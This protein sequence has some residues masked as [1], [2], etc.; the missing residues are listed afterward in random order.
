MTKGKILVTGGAG[1]IGSHTCLVLL[2]SGYDLIVIDSFVNSSPIALKKVKQ[3]ASY[4]NKN[5]I[6]NIQVVEGDIRDGSV[7]EN[8]FSQANKSNS[9]IDGVI[10]FVGLKAVEESIIKPLLYWDVNV[11]GTSQLLSVMDSYKC[12]TIVFSSSATIYGYPSENPIKESAPSQPINTYGETK[13]AVEK[14]LNSVHNSNKNSW[15]ISSLRYFNPAGA[16]GSGEI[17]EDPRNIPNNIFPFITQVAVGRLKMLKVFGSDWPTIDGSGVRDY[18]HVMDLAEAH[19]ITLEYLI[20][21][22]PQNITLNL[23]SGRGTSVLE[24]ISSFEKNSGKSISY[25]VTDRRPGDAATTIADPSL[26]NSLLGW[27]TKRTI[28]DICK[29]G[30]KWQKKNPKGY[31]N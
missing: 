26:A 22:K 11:N 16:H 14:M 25:Q 24:L 6:G 3:I 7:L 8:I 19:V 4:E 10:H 21:N 20:K 9:P 2:K 29:D 28:D 30:W 18:I 15:R 13:L 5:N 31:E 1:F 12:R 27:K 23:G 17:G